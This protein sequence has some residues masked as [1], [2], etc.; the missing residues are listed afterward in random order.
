MLDSICSCRSFRG[1]DVDV[2]SAGADGADGGGIIAVVDEGDWGCD[3]WEASRGLGFAVDV[4][5]AL[6]FLLLL[7][8]AT[9]FAAA[10]IFDGVLGARGLGTPISLVEPT[11]SSPDIVIDEEDCKL[12]LLL[13]W[14]E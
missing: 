2:V 4:S 9:S 8:P 7:S 5:W 6:S 10:C 13:R 11:A 3:G 14:V 12:L 1:L